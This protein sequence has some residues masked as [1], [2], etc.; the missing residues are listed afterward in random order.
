MKNI[1]HYIFYK[2]Y[3]YLLTT[4]NTASALNG[5]TIYLCITIF[6]Y[7]LTID[8]L[9]KKVYKLY[10]LSNNLF[11]II[12]VLVSIVTFY[13]N[14]FYF[15]KNNLY[16]KIDQRFSKENKSQKLLGNIFVFLLFIGSFISFMLFGYLINKN[17]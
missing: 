16:V 6:F 4:P 7:L 15:K 1:Y 11:M 9:F 5:A 10:T 13:I 3:R 17:L 12:G 14:Y 2:F 8:I